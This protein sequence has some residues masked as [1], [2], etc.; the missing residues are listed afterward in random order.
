MSST[1]H[2]ELKDLPSYRVAAVGGR[3][4]TL[5]LGA[6]P[7][8]ITEQVQPLGD[9]LLSW[10]KVVGLGRNRTPGLFGLS[11]I[12]GGWT[13]TGESKSMAVKEAAQEFVQ[14]LPLGQDVLSASE[15]AAAFGIEGLAKGKSVTIRH[16]RPGMYAVARIKGPYSNLSA[17][18]EELMTE[19]LPSSGF[20]Y[21]NEPLLNLYVND[22][23]TTAPE[24][25]LTD[26]CVPLAGY[27][28]LPLGLF[29]S[30]LESRSE[31]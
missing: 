27:R 9:N 24:D 20:S 19:W 3:A 12:D 16:T 8:T 17:V 7:L 4:Q 21:D 5:E 25:L 23:D 30:F 1:L 26:F 28:Q 13:A 31:A 6:Q 15:I 10:A 11:I 2:V 22:P 18:A 29:G 14:G